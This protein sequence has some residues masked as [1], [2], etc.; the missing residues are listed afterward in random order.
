L[1]EAERRLSAL[2]VDDLMR[3]VVRALLRYAQPDA[4][5][6]MRAVLNLKQLAEAAG[7][8]MREAHRAVIQLVDQKLVQVVEDGLVLLDRDAL[9]AC[10]DAPE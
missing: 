2:G 10:F 9:D 8:S 7:L 1:I 4:D 3:P 5:D 6:G